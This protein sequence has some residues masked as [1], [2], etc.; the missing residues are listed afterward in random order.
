MPTGGRNGK[1]NAVTVQEHSDLNESVA[2]PWWGSGKPQ[3]LGTL[4]CPRN[5]AGTVE[6]SISGEMQDLAK[7]FQACRFSRG[8]CRAKIKIPQQK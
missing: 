4:S 6:R 2:D 7:E 8:G 1:R 3:V 5:R